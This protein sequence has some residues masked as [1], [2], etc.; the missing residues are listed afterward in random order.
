M[1]ALILVGG[2][3]TRLRPLTLS[4]P[5]PL[6]DFCNKPILL[7]QV[8]ALAA[9]G[10][11]HVILAVSYMSQVLEKEMKAQEQRLG[12]RISMS[13]EEEPLGTGFWMDI[14]QPK[15][16]L[17][18]MCLFLQSLRQKQPE[19]LCSGPGIVGNVLVDPS[20]RIGQNC[21]IGPNVSLGPGVVVE[22]GVCIRRCTVLR[23]AHIR[24]HS[25]LESCI[26]G[27]RCRVGQWPA[28]SPG[29]AHGERD[30][31]GRGRDRQRRALPQR[32]QRAAAQVHRRV[33]AGATHHHVRAPQAELPCPRAGVRALDLRGRTEGHRSLL[34]TCLLRGLPTGHPA[35]GPL[36][37][38]RAAARAVW[39]NNLML[40]VALTPSSAQAQLGPWLG[41]HQSDCTQARRLEVAGKVAG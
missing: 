7:H 3:G 41:S 1:K 13:H 6:V 24:S 29:G 30:C 16:F 36:P 22:D 17:T 26:V 4:T 38:R 23:D 25:W 15:D 5:K 21:S 11:D 12:I 31:A 19:R 39:N 10:V 33:G 32:G 8:E 28:L 27:W 37:R 2:Y 20:A 9:A 18:G 14:G 40:A 35:H 34:D